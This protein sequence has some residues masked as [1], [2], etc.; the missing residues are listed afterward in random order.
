MQTLTGR[1]HVDGSYIAAHLGFDA[2]LDALLEHRADPNSRTATGESVLETAVDGGYGD[3]V[4]RYAPYSFGVP[5][6]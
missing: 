4:H 3:I 1:L 2:C 5:S 6:V